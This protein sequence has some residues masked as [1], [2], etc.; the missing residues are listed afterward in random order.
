MQKIKKII[1]I[2]SI[3]LS[4]NSQAQSNNFKWQCIK[5]E[6]NFI[7]F[8]PFEGYWGVITD[9]PIKAAKRAGTSGSGTLYTTGT[10]GSLDVNSQAFRF[11]DAAMKN[12]LVVYIETI[13]L[14]L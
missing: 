2:I 6:N 13:C 1:F 3:L 8:Y 12:N 5:D 9:K 7:A 11:A 10:V 4:F 14:A